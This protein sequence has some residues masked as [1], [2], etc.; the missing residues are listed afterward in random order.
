[1][2]ASSD[3]AHFG[4]RAEPFSKEIGDADLWLP[5]S[6]PGFR[7]TLDEGGFR[8]GEAGWGRRSLAERGESRRS[9]HTSPF[10]PQPS[11]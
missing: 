11:T 3:A 6:K 2:T 8:R 7:S 9:R 10:P 4:L 5:S 1:M